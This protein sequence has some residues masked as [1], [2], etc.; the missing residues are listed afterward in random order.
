MSKTI[1]IEGKYKWSLLLNIDNSQNTASYKRTIKKK[2]IKDIVIEDLYE[3]IFEKSEKKLLCKK[4]NLDLSATYKIIAGS[5]SINSENEKL[6]LIDEKYKQIS[7]YNY[8]IHQEYEKE[9][10]IEVG[11]QSK[12]KLYQLE[13]SG[14]GLH[15]KTDIIS[16]E[17]CSIDH[18]FIDVNIEEVLFLKSIDVVYTKQEIERPDSIIKEINNLSADI[19]S[20]FGGI[21]VW[22]VPI[23]TKN[24]EEALTD[25]DVIIQKE[26][27]YNHK[28]LSY[29]LYK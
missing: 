25:I 29:K 28:D 3:K 23:Y 11:P 4:Y 8:K 14:P 16:S 2:I 27:N 22:L 26:S 10:I 24:C 15:Y 5:I 12:F 21:Y 6:M 20:S 18:V 9:E 13:Y 7:N 17:P 1:S 19:N